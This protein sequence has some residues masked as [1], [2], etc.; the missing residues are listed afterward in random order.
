MTRILVISPS[1]EV[2]DHDCVRWYGHLGFATDP[3]HYHN[4]G[5][6][7]VYDSSLKLLR[8]S[9][10]AGLPSL[11]WLEMKDLKL[12]EQCPQDDYDIS[13]PSIRGMYMEECGFPLFDLP[14]RCPNVT[15]VILRD[16]FWVSRAEWDSVTFA[17]ERWP[18][19]REVSLN[20]F[21]SAEYFAEFY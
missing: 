12:Q 20:S 15:N 14:S 17:K 1:G 21:V 11:R 7:F 18:P 6:A 10:L 4:I 5:D 16:A 13:Y 19:L 3:D 8:F 2:H 9:A